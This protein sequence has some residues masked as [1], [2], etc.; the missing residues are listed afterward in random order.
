M[1]ATQGVATQGG[2]C[3]AES[4]CGAVRK[5]V[6][7][8]SGSP[9]SAVTVFD[10]QPSGW[11]SHGWMPSA[12]N[13]KGGWSPLQ[14]SGTR[15]P[16]RPQMVCPDRSQMGSLS[17]SSGRSVISSRLRDTGTPEPADLDGVFRRLKSNEFDLV[18]I[19]RLHL[20]DPALART[21]RRGGPIPTFDRERHEGQLY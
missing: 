1:A 16:S 5:R 15:H 10:F 11:G 9:V 6:S 17:S 13:P 14:G 19:G 8:E 21:L 18:A 3:A 4:E 7:I 12:V 2:Q 20:A